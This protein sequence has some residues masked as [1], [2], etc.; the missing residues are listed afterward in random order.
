MHPVLLISIILGYFIVLMFVS[1]V[2]SRG[3]T[4]DSFFI[5]NHKS[6][7]YLVAF[8]MIGTSISGVTF[9]SVPGFVHDTGFSYLQMI[10]GNFVGYIIIATILMP[11]YY[12]LKLTSIYSYLDVRFGGHSYKTGAAF[13]ILSRTR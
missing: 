6:P 9:V 4:N 3:A 13:F 12:K 5:G 7:W 1:W 10:L 2:T 11:M 8:G